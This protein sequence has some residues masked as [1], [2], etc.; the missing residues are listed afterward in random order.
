MKNIN[1]NDDYDKIK[2]LLDNQN[3]NYK[4]FYI[5]GPKGDK[6]E[7]G[8]STIKIGTTKTGSENDYAEV[9][10]VGT[11]ENAILNFIIPRG[12]T[13]EKGENG[14]DGD[15]II[16]GKTTT[17]DANARAKVVDTVVGNTH[18]LDFYIPQGFDGADGDV[19]PKGEDGKTYYT[20]IKYADT[21]ETGIS[22]NPEGKTYLGI[23][24]NKETNNPTNNYSDYKWSL[25]KGDKGTDGKSETIQIEETKTIEP[26]E[27]AKVEDNF[28]GNT[29]HLTF[30]IPKGKDGTTINTYA[31]I[32]ETNAN[33]ITLNKDVSTQIQLNTIGE[34]NNIN[35]TFTSS[36]KIKEEGT[37]KIDY[38]YYG[39]SSANA[40]ISLQ[41]RKDN[42][43]IPGT[44]ITK[45]I[46]QDEYISLT[47]NTIQKL[48]K[49]NLI[50]LGLIS[51][52][53]VTLTPNDDLS[54]YLSVLKIN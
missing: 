12:K 34:N 18:T 3:R 15:K 14:K 51:N 21:R 33:S 29:H 25:I 13:G 49:D 8:S 44:K 5:K 42:N 7:D 20:W 48:Q 43:E 10:N 24:S 38:F 50:D 2:K 54:C 28:D 27:N 47:G 39:K 40:T 1:C 32:Y 22:D 35:T 4:I 41:L 31:Y 36:L 26:G 45:E 9:E 11:D 52:I 6:G 53:E 46:K 19:G 17:L 37:Y 16:I 30:L 23:A